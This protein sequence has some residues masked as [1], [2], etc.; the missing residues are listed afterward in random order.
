MDAS[1]RRRERRA[2]GRRATAGQRRLL[3]A[4]ALLLGAM[5]AVGVAVSRVPAA[6]AVLEGG[7]VDQAVPARSWALPLAVAGAC[8]VAAVWCLVGAVRTRGDAQPP[9]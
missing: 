3:L 1:G 2:A 7:R 8:A 4:S 9:H 6:Y 5:L